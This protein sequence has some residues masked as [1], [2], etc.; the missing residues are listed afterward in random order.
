M[1]RAEYKTNLKDN[2]V[3]CGKRLVKPKFIFQSEN[4]HNV[5]P[6]VVKNI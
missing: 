5:R 2:V 3:A 4:I 6:N 1:N